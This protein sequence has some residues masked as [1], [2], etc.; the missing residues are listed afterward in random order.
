M[1]KESLIRVTGARAESKSI[2]GSRSS[3]I[4]RVPAALPGLQLYPRE[5]PRVRHVDRRDSMPSRA[6]GERVPEDRAT[7]MTRWSRGLV[8]HHGDLPS[9]AMR[10]LPPAL[11]GNVLAGLPFLPAPRPPLAMVLRMLLTLLNCRLS[12]GDETPHPSTRILPNRSSHNCELFDFGSP[13][14][15]LSFSPI[16][17]I[18][19]SPPH[20]LSSPLPRISLSYASSLLPSHPAARFYLT[21][22]HPFP[23]SISPFSLSFLEMLV[24]LS[25]GFLSLLGPFF[26]PLIPLAPPPLLSLLFSHP[27][28]I[29]RP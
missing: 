23:V 2:R 21:D 1:R 5:L 26:F 13:L 18:R 3:V 20:T 16:A 28:W 25:P 27:F 4:V 11:S 29:L 14:C 10:P 7:V 9:L 12:G 24:G 17:T 15:S 8:G 22:F 19:D 6:T